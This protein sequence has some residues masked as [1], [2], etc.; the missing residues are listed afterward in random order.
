M[1]QQVSYD[2]LTSFAAL[3]EETADALADIQETRSRKHSN[4]LQALYEHP[5]YTPFFLDMLND[6]YEAEYLLEQDASRQYIIAAFAMRQAA[7][8][9]EKQ[10]EA[11][12][13][14]IEER[15]ATPEEVFYFQQLEFSR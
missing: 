4:I 8:E 11:I 10:H 13:P 3:V 14:Y 9:I 2:L 5:A 12:Q 6:F 15:Q 1:T 7:K